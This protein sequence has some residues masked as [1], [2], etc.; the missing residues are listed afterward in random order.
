MFQSQYSRNENR[1]N[2]CSQDI[3]TAR[4]EDRKTDL[5][6]YE[7]LDILFEKLEK[8]EEKLNGKE[9]K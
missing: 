6:V 1:R 7:A 2:W 3:Y 5:R 4:L 8:I 9:G